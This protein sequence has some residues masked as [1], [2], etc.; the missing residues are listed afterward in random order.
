MCIFTRSGVMSQDF[1]CIILLRDCGG[2]RKPRSGLDGRAKLESVTATTELR[3]L[4][5]CPRN[6]STGAGE[7]CVERG[8][9][10]LLVY[11]LHY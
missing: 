9:G 4:E 11:Y 6:I 3:F 8:A 7:S 1:A 10:C 5:R 2:L